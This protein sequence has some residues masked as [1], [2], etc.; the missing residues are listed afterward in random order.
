L[1]TGPDFLGGGI[2][3]RPGFRKAGECLRRLRDFN[4]V[5]ADGKFC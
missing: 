4:G 2:S 5:N 1:G 3:F